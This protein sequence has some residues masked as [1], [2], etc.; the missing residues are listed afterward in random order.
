[1]ASMNDESKTAARRE[2][3]TARLL[4][5]QIAQQAAGKEIAVWMDAILALDRED[6]GWRPVWTGRNYEMRKV[7]C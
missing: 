3:F 7:N 4:S 6:D 5:A 2:A 1:M